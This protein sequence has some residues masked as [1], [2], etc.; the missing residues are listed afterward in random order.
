M[1][2]LPHLLDNVEVG[3]PGEVGVC[4]EK[5]GWLA[6]LHQPGG[7][8]YQMNE[9]NIHDVKNME[10]DNARDEMNNDRE[11]MNIPDVFQPLCDWTN[12]FRHH[13]HQV[14]GS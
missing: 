9:M 4:V 10:I 5:T 7:G 11:E 2:L 13:L 12:V 1:K 6:R 8:R 14:L 3:E